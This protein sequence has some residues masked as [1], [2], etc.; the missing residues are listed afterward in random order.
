[1]VPDSLFRPREKVYLYLQN[2]T[3]G[4]KY[5]KQIKIRVDTSPWTAGVFSGWSQ[6]IP[7]RTGGDAWAPE[8]DLKNQSTELYK[9]YI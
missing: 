3:K 5:E 6:T 8:N 9:K 7:S 1:M 4:V 2:F